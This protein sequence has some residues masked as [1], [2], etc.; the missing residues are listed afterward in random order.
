MGVPARQRIK[1]TADFEAVRA[2]GWK[3]S[4]RHFFLQID[5]TPASAGFERRRLG[6]IASRRVGN[7]VVRNR[8]KRLMREVFRRRQELLPAHCDVVMVARSECA[9]AGYSE[10]ESSF[11]GL[12][13][14]FNKWHAKRIEGDLQ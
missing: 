7:A 3:N 2:S 9:E 14:R 4:S 6:V 10:V 8:C 11:V 13:E 1:R 12:A 5:A